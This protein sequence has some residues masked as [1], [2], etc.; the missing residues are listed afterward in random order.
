MVRTN[1][2]NRQF[3]QS[4]YCELLSVEFFHSI[5]P[6]DESGLNCANV[7]EELKLS[8]ISDFDWESQIAF[9]SS[10]FHEL[11]VS[12]LR[13]LSLQLICVIIS[14]HRLRLLTEDSLYQFI[15]DRLSVDAD[16]SSLLAFVR[17]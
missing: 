15:T 14:R 11:Q 17:F 5:F 2:A 8:S 7:F 3:F 12:Q 1:D 4:I 6:L 9:R 13:D 10:H 16:C